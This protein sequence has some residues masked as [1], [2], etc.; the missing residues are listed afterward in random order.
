RAR[1]PEIERRMARMQ[2]HVRSLRLP[3]LL[4]RG[5]LS[6]VLSEEG[7]RDF[8]KLCPHAEY[9]SVADAAHMVAGDRNDIF[10]AAVID[11]LS[12]VV[13]VQGTP[14][15]PSHLRRPHRLENIADIP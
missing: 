3:T 13:P 8:C 2:E 12:R 9:V 15:Q 11:F 4:V 1:P 14:A 6:D 5:A 7:A 10:T